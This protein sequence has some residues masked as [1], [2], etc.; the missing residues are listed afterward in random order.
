MPSSAPA[1]PR[2]PAGIMPM[3]V[4]NK[5]GL[6]ITANVIVSLNPDGQDITVEAAPMALPQGSW[7]VRW[8]L[9]VVP[10]PGFRAW[11]HQ[12]GIVID[13]ADLPA[14]VTLDASASEDTKEHCVR[15][16]GNSVKGA[17]Q[18]SYLIVVGW[19]KAGNSDSMIKKIHDPTIAV[20]Q[21]PVGKLLG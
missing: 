6:V 10:S 1:N 11:F 3:V 21:D 2:P 13:A 5:P 4:H 17:N 9:M 16:I 18:F 7:K 20:T 15:L 14:N 12:H 19:S 8:E